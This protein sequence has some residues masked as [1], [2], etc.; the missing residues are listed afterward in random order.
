[1]KIGSED[2]LNTPLHFAAIF[3]H[4]ETFNV[5]HS[6]NIADPYMLNLRCNMALDLAPQFHSSINPSSEDWK[7]IKLKIRNIEDSDLLDENEFNNFECSYDKLT[8]V[9][10]EYDYVIFIRRT[11]K[12]LQNEIKFAKNKN[13]I[14]KK[15]EIEKNEEIIKP[16]N[17]QK[18]KEN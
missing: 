10:I 15:K 8:S 14:I 6:M 18:D 12:D 16:K 3:N 2:Y 13:E 5:I 17:K 9:R 4:C 1:M 7:K 11:L